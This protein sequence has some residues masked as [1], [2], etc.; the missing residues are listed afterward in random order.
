MQEAVFAVH[1]F[2]LEADSHE[3]GLVDFE[4][5]S[6]KGDEIVDHLR[7]YLIDIRDWVILNNQADLLR[8]FPL[9]D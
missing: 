7:P 4:H 8:S 9:L 6:F 2:E 5:Y 3:F 1:A